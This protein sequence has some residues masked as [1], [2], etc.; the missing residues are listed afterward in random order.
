[1][2]S[3]K[4]APKPEG[5]RSIPV[6][7]GSGPPIP[8]EPVH[9]SKDLLLYLL[10]TEAQSEIGKDSQPNPGN[11]VAAESPQGSAE[12]GASEAAEER[13]L[14]RKSAETTVE[15]AAVCALLALVGGAFFG[16]GWPG[17]VAAC[18]ISLMGAVVGY[19]QLK[20]VERGPAPVRNPSAGSHDIQARKDP[21]VH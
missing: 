3:E 4:T 16:A 18:G 17:A 21:G 9:D 2:D 10:L 14:A 12:P 15:A 19:F 13:K 5:K 8:T 20:H 1:M 7:E 11:E 6:P